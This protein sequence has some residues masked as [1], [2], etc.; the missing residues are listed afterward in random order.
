MAQIYS[1][2]ICTEKTNVVFVGTSYFFHSNFFGL[3]A[4]AERDENN[5]YQFTISVGNRYTI[6]GR[7]IA[8][9]VYKA[10][11]KF[12]EKQYNNKEMV[13]TRKD[14]DLADNSMNVSLGTY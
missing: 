10:V 1:I 2:S 6:G 9:K 8:S 12:L 4:V 3:L 5:D 7:V 14:I 11:C 13:F